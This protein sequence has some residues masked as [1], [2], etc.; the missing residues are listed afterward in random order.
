MRHGHF[1]CEE[2]G[3]LMIGMPSVAFSVIIPLESH[4]GLAERCIWQWTREQD[5][6]RES[7]QVIIA[8]PRGHNRKELDV[9][10]NFLGHRDCMLLLPHRHDMPLVAAAAQEAAGDAF[11]FTEA[12]CL[13]RPDALSRSAE[14]LAQHPDWAGFSGRSIPITHNLLSRIEA[15]MYDKDIRRNLTEHPWLKVLDQCL[16][17]RREAYFV[18]GGI[19][20]EYGHFAEWLLAARLY[21]KTLKINYYPEVAISHY[22]IGQLRELMDFTEDFSEGQIRF[23]A[24]DCEDPCKL[25]FDPIQAWEMR[26]RWNRRLSQKLALVLVRDAFPFAGNG[27]RLV[28]RRPEGGWSL[29]RRTMIDAACGLRGRL[30]LA[31]LRAELLKLAVH[32]HLWWGNREKS[33]RGFH[34][35]MAQSARIGHLLGMCGLKDKSGASR[36][37]A[38]DLDTDA[39]YPGSRTEIRMLG[40]HPAETV[41]G[42][43][44]QWSEA[45]AIVE[46][47][48]PLGES[49][50]GVSWRKIRSDNAN[51][52]LRFYANEQLVLEDQLKRKLFSVEIVLRVNGPEPVRL[53]WICKPFDAP[54][55]SRS[56]GLPISRIAWSSVSFPQGDASHRRGNLQPSR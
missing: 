4:R 37:S 41:E 45:A 18:T 11:F 40:F 55:D 2:S 7:Y 35:L 5:F 12:H 21:V 48:L 36:A 56:R 16:V 29:L 32:G 30:V 47:P 17:V 53:S 51:A 50:I 49:T 43:A 1:G 31:Q 39:W 9:L 24:R 3:N 23:A 52:G 25:M 34:C 42:A 27:R 19:E 33:Q 26:H 38:R 14:A 22:Y 15:E 13:P 46:L 8:A 44:F 28:F 20:V 6:P 54:G 10:K